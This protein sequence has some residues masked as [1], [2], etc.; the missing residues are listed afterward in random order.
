MWK[1]DGLK[2]VGSPQDVDPGRVLMIIL[3]VKSKR[4]GLAPWNSCVKEPLEET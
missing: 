1:E 4:T 2:T 3:V